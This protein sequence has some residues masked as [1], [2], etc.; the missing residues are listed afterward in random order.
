MFARYWIPVLI[1]TVLAACGGPPKITDDDIQKVL[2]PQLVDM[3]ESPGK[4]PPVLVDVRTPERFREGHI[5]GAINI[6]FVDL[7]EDHSAFAGK[8]PIILYSGSWTDALSASAS[9]KLMNRGMD[10]ERLHDFRGGMDYWDKSGGR[11][12]KG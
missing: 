7:R 10:P 3:M 11:I 2:Y 8:G 12:V 4:H 1:V 5:P 6:P 9:K